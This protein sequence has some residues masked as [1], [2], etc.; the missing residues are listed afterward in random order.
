MRWKIK[1][2]P[3]ALAAEFTRELGLYSIVAGVLAARGLS[4]VE[5]ARRFINPSLAGDWTNPA[6]IA[7]MDVIALRLKEA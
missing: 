3:A 5:E 6:D 1:P 4:T 7:D 2:F